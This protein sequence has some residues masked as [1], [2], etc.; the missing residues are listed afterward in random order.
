M[1]GYC[2]AIATE[3]AQPVSHVALPESL[4][5]QAEQARKRDH[6]P[7]VAI[8]A[9]FT[10]EPVGEP[11]SFVLGEL[12]MK[13]RPAFA[14]YQQ[15]FQQLLDPASLVRTTDGF[16]VVLVR[17]ED[18]LHGNTGPEP[19]HLE[20]LEQFTDELI[21]ALQAAQHGTAPLIVCS[22]PCITG[23]RGKAGLERCDASA[24]NES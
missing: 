24:R 5:R 23:G 9:S 15:V 17:F 19:G 8:T 1:P 18:W 22:L 7:M 12:G 16:A 21:A 11:L 14:P 4:I 10:A 3:P 20:K 2:R 13:Y 6:V